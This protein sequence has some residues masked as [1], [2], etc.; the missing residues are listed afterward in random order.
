MGHI[1]TRYWQLPRGLTRAAAWRYLRGCDI[2]DFRAF[3]YDPKTGRATT[4]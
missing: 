3:T 1:Q 2:P 4:T